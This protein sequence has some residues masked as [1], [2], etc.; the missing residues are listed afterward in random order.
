MF[1][2][3]RGQDKSNKLLLI[4]GIIGG[5]HGLS[6]EGGAFTTQKANKSIWVINL[7][8]YS[9][10]ELLLNPNDPFYLQFTSSNMQFCRD[11]DIL[12]IV[13]GYGVKNVNDA[14]SDYTFDKIVSVQVS[15]MIR[16]VE[17]Q[18]NGDA[19]KAILDTASSPFIQVTGGELVKVADAF[20]L[21][22]GQNYGGVYQPGQTGNYT[23]SVR[24]FRFQNGQITD[25]G[26]YINEAILHRRDIPVA[27]VIQQSG[28]FY[29]A[30][31]GVFTSDDNGYANPVYIN[32]NKDSFSARQDTLI[33]KT[34]QY[35]CAKVSFYNPLTDANT[36]VLLGGIGRYQYNTTTHQ[37][38]DGDDGA[39]LP[40][41]KTITQM[42][43]KD[44]VM[45]Q[46]IQIPPL[47]PE[48]PDFVGANA[49][50]LANTSFSYSDSEEII[51]HGKLPAGISSVGILYGGI[52]SLRPT[53]STIYP[54]SI[55]T[56]IYEVFAYKFNDQN[57]DLPV[58]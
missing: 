34:N 16:Q 7:S 35:K 53:S 58:T 32:I 49:M 55:N 10:S 52:K 57:K 54:T 18:G 19:K 41:V 31:G 15:E 27:P 46:Y 11:G 9:Y 48:L 2:Q 13:G 29:A 30:F 4:G 26:S 25:T 42:I 47:Y 17:L 36:I 6:Q 1:N 56:T 51:D 3:V 23:N 21:M 24:K 44:G 38:E 50:F 12:Y 43:F 33:Q 14:Q 37:W 22:F 5:F 20:Y 28:T 39:K 45:K 8:D 40:F